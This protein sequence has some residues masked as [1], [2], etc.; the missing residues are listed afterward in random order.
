MNAIRSAGLAWPT[1]P[2]VSVRVW[3][4]VGAGVAVA[5]ATATALAAAATRETSSA[6]VGSY[7]G[8]VVGLTALWTLVRRSRS[9]LPLLLWPLCIL[10]DLVCAAIWAPTAASVCGATIVL[11]FLFAGLTQPRGTS[12]LLIPPA[13][14]TLMV[15][16]AALPPRQLLIRM[17]IGS[18]VW[19]ASTEMPAW[20]TVKLRFARAELA[21]LAATDPLTGLANRRQWEERLAEM[22]AVD[23]T[24]A[25]LL[26]DLDHF[27]RFN[28]DHGHLAGD[29]MLVAFARAIEQ[30]TPADDIAS[31]WGGEEF[32]IALREVSTAQRVAETI[33]RTVPLGQTCSIGLVECQRDEPLSSIMHR[34]DG[35]LYEAKTGGRNRVV[36][37]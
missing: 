20:L 19:A 15:I 6:S 4:N 25:V 23:G 7:V 18:F 26:V 33:R 10:A 12:L 27:K 13:L 34:A 1:V 5:T 2:V 22:L 35:A 8:L 29:E 32:A 11:G 37:A 9:R 28:D 3:H 21:R 14:L 16:N 17:A 24:V 36:A 31:R 30:A